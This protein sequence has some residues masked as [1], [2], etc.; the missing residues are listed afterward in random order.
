MNA[1]RSGNVAELL[2]VVPSESESI[3]FVYEESSP[4]QLAVWSGQ[5]EMVRILLWHGADPNRANSE[6]T[7]PLERAQEYGLLEMA[8]LLESFGAIT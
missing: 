8:D 4:L 2:Q 1:I 6:G 3:D 7:R 5:T